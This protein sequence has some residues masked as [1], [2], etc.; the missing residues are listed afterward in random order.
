MP[1]KSAYPDQIEGT[2]G[3]CGK[4]VVTCLWNGVDGWICAACGLFWSR[5]SQM[6]Q[7]TPDDAQEGVSDNDTS[8]APTETTAVRDRRSSV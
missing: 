1:R 3:K 5:E 4:P 2:C 7:I 8:T 6:K